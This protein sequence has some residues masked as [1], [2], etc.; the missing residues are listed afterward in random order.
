MKKVYNI[1]A[2]C[3]DYYDYLGITFENEKEAIEFCEL[4]INSKYI[5]TDRVITG[6]LHYEESFIY[7]NLIDYVKNNKQCIEYLEDIEEI[8]AAKF[9]THKN[10]Y[11]KLI[12]N[13]TT[14]D[15]E[16]VM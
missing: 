9:G 2:N 7:D 13:A 14:D 11:N 1:Y 12:L 4:F 8:A 5:V 16:L 10:K 15:D 6:K 3:G